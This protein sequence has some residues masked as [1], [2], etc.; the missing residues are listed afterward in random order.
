MSGK[1]ISFYSFKGGVGRTMALA[2]VAFI[3]AL[4]GKRVLVIDWD[5]EAPGLSYYFR[6]LIN[7]R[8]AKELRHASGILN[9]VWDWSTLINGATT[10]EDVTAIVANVDNGEFFEGLTTRLVDDQMLAD[11]CVLD[12]IGPG[13]DVIGS[14]EDAVSYEAALGDFS[15]S[16]FFSDSAGGLMIEGLRRW[17]KANYDYVFVDSRTGLADDAGVC[18]VQIPD[19]VALCFVLNRQNIDGV[20]KVAGVIRSA[21]RGEVET[22]C[23]TMRMASTGSAE[24]ADAIARARRQLGK[25]GR[26]DSEALDFDL[27]RLL[28]RSQPVSYHESLAAISANVAQR[29][30]LTLDFLNLAVE[31][32]S[33]PFSIPILPEDLLE[34]ARERLR[35]TQA[36]SDYLVDLRS[37]EPDRSIGEVL[38]LLDN[39]R[40]VE[41]D[42]EDLD[43][44]YVTALAT[45][46]ALVAEKIATELEAGEILQ[47][48]ADLLRDLYRTSPGKWRLQFADTLE[49][50]VRVSAVYDLLD[51]EEL[52]ALEELET[53]LTVEDAG[54]ALT[55]RRIAARR[56]IIRFYIKYGMPEESL[57]AI[58]E[59][60]ALLKAVEPLFQTA[61]E[62]SDVMLAQ[63]DLQMLRG[64]VRRAQG[65]S[66]GAVADWKRAFRLG[67]KGHVGERSEL[68]RALFE[69][70]V[71]LANHDENSGEA[72]GFALAAARLHPNSGAFAPHFVSLGQVV[73]KQ[74][75]PVWVSEYLVEALGKETRLANST[76]TVFL[77]RN[78]GTSEGLL[79]LA[80]PMME[81]LVD[82]KAKNQPATALLSALVLSSLRALHRRQT[83]G[84][85]VLA[86]SLGAM[87][88]LV[89][90][91][92]A[93]AS[94]VLTVEEEE[95][96][97]TV[98]KWLDTRRSERS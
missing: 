7:S 61:D 42:G 69:L 22:R 12:Y 41:I 20:A 64:D 25:T 58:E 87:S 24:E 52:A 5:L 59:T 17:A 39:A 47:R 14:G 90:R 50:I 97:A 10:P 80:I 18:T 66:G 38:R 45:T 34:R 16:S 81:L 83:H 85:R 8:T 86:R 65:N 43:D 94:S 29:D 37:A 70:A 93:V 55:L 28:V 95:E 75:D 78:A 1:V 62:R 89:R 27:K 4:N 48:C 60:R 54:P 57:R 74:G 32:C 91:W 33:E 11:Q 44:E 3:A 2:N 19:A 77:G 88:G 63:L 6:G 68:Q 31:L 21:R 56:R 71:K 67:S 30:P 13:N 76:F 15:W 36:T 82:F 26:L 35:P 51:E 84:S 92:L 73:L 72:V 40:A 79:L 53:I 23:V 98:L 9:L 49:R 96:W 46:A